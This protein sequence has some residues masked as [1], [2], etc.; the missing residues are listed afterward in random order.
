MFHKNIRK[1][2][3][4]TEHADFVARFCEK[5]IASGNT[6]YTNVP[7]QYW[8]QTERRY[9]KGKIDIVAVKNNFVTAYE[10]ETVD[11]QMKSRA[12]L[13]AFKCDAAYIICH[14]GRAN[15]VK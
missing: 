7:Q 3:R 2:R 5:L 10:L 8:S 1:S 11:P 6:V 13:I 9:I 14:S 4:S 15:R 12:K